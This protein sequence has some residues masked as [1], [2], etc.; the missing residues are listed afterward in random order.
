MPDKLP[1]G[2]PVVQ[3]DDTV[4]FE[5]GGAEK[6]A[7]GDERPVAVLWLI[8]PEQRHGFREYYVKKQSPTK[9][10]GKPMGYRK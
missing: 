8:D 7:D 2:E 6:L 1:I 3:P 5:V 10:N 9:P 4:V